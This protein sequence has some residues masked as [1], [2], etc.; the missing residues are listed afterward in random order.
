MSMFEILEGRKLFSVALVGTQLQVTGDTGGTPNDVI[1][2]SQF[3]A[4]TLRVEENGTVQFFA[5]SSVSS[6]LI[7]A[8]AGDDVAEV[9]STPALPLDEPAV[10]NGGAGND[11]VRGGSGADVLN[12]N[13]G[14]DVIRAGPGNDSL[15]GGTGNNQ[16]FGENGNDSMTAGLGADV[17]DGGFNTDT[18]N[19]STRTKGLTI[20]LDGVANDGELIVV[21]QPFPLPPLGQIPEGDDVRENVE[22]VIGGAGGDL[23]VAG[24]TAVNNTFDGR[25]G[26]DR[27][28][29]RGGADN[30]IG[31]AGDDTLL[32][33]VSGDLLQG[34]TGNDRLLGGAGNDDLR[35]GDNDDVLVGGA[36]VDAMRG[37]AGNDVLIAS[38]TFADTLIDG[39]SGFDIADVDD[40]LDP[41][42]VSVELLA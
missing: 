42:A 18:V 1:R 29:G 38:D 41:V 28:E 15:N 14:N 17:F 27:L 10:I 8:G 20:S 39:G 25:G 22:N 26:N 40:L 31:G 21:Q 32:G 19:Y 24:P 35:G 34:G 33:G 36:G 37:E 11:Q 7:N 5:D 23:I 3:D 30:L 6:I 12:G 2:I 16:L 9:T 4:A 13:E